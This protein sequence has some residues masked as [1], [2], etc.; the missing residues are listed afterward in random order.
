MY[1]SLVANRGQ[2]ALKCGHK[3]WSEDSWYSQRENDARFTTM[4][5]DAAKPVRIESAGQAIDAF[6][7]SSPRRIRC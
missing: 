2:L 1:A 7:F 5:H 4:S 3:R 6:E